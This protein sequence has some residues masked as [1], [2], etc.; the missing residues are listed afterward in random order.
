M[1]ELEKLNDASDD[2]SEEDDYIVCQ[3]S[4]EVTVYILA[5]DEVHTDDDSGDEQHVTLSNLPGRQL[6][7]DALLK[8]VENRQEENISTFTV[9]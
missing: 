1:E 9:K 7:S 8:S 2:A 5:P 3:K 4:N 6:L